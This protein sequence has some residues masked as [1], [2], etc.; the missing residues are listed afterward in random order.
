M[1]ELWRPSGVSPRHEVS[2]EGRV[3]SITGKIL[4]P[5]KVTKGNRY[6]L[7]FNKQSVSITG[8]VL[9]DRV[10]PFE[11]IKELHDDEEV[12]PL[13]KYENEYYLT[14]Y[15][16]VYKCGWGWLCVVMYGPK[17]RQYPSVQ[18]DGK[19]YKIHRLLGE[20]FIPNPHGHPC[21]LHG[22]DD[23]L[24]YTLSNLRWGTPKDNMDDQF[25]N[26]RR[27]LNTYTF[28][29]EGEEVTTS[30][31]SQWCRDRGLNP[32]SVRLRLRRGTL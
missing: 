31:L 12:V 22:D 21:V 14:S 10:F 19:Y 5:N 30:H 16:R 1:T 9:R 15:G 27:P 11:W 29:W 18:L 13:R 3:R 26:N 17:P 32:H 8:K 24:N 7:R 6:I 25:K 28:M 20:Y 2:N 4:K 23:P